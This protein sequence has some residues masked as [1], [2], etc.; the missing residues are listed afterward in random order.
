MFDP[1]EHPGLT[2]EAISPE[3]PQTDIEIMSVFLS[4]Y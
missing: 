4:F 1:V 3:L 2:L